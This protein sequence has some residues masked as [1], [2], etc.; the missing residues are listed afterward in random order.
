MGLTAS[1]ATNICQRIIVVGMNPEEPHGAEGCSISEGELH[2]DTCAAE[3]LELVGCLTVPAHRRPHFPPCIFRLQYPRNWPIANH[4]KLWN[5]NYTYCLWLQGKRALPRISNSI[6]TRAFLACEASTLDHAPVSS[7]KSHILSANCSTP[8][9]SQCYRERQ[10]SRSNFGFSY[11][12][13]ILYL[14]SFC[15]LQHGR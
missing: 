4:I 2:E 14:T 5:I 1:S 6:G 7:L 3:S 13:P 9:A 10:L 8:S 11:Y 12:Q 15:E